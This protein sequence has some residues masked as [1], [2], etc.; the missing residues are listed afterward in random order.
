MWF[1]HCT[2]GSHAMSFHWLAWGTLSSDWLRVHCHQEGA[3]G[4]IHSCGHFV[5]FGC[6]CLSG[7]FGGGMMYEFT[8][9]WW[10]MDG[11]ID[12]VLELTGI[13]VHV[14]VHQAL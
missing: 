3:L 8:S 14:H 11:E 4:Y 12:S 1:M 5:A 13:H 7:W 2:C 6:P 9:F 10:D